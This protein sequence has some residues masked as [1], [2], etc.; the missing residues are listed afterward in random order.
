MI[1]Y[2]S[3]IVL[4]VKILFWA[5]LFSILEVKVFRQNM[6]G[7]TEIIIVI[8]TGKVRTSTTFPS[9]CTARINETP[10]VAGLESTMILKTVDYHGDLRTTGG[11]PISADVYSE[12]SGM[13]LQTSVSDLENGTY[14][15]HF[16]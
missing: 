11:D 6:S 10:A 12:P 8:I 5:F 14:E 16:R 15:I 9:L 1:S 2:F 7:K 4:V 13:L 3:K